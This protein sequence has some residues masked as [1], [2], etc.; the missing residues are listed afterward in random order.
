[1]PEACL[2]HS[3]PDQYCVTLWRLTG[4]SEMRMLHTGLLAHCSPWHRL[5]VALCGCSY[6]PATHRRGQSLILTGKAQVK[7]FARVSDSIIGWGSSVGRWARI[8][9]KSV[10]GEDVHVKVQRYCCLSCVKLFSELQP[11]P[12][13]IHIDP[14]PSYV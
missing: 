13:Y 7:D 3:A 10:I 5:I 14:A 12:I 4:L 8:D 6:C 11:H 2:S 9:N 1:M